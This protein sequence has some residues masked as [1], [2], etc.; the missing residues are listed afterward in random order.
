MVHVHETYRLY[1]LNLF[2]AATGRNFHSLT[3]HEACNHA[4]KYVNGVEGYGKAGS[5]VGTARPVDIDFFHFIKLL[6][7]F[8]G[9]DIANAGSPAQTC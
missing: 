3:V 7:P 2:L 1:K 5:I 9:K 8:S 6:G 4:G